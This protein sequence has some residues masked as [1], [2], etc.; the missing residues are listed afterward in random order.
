MVGVPR[1][2]GSACVYSGLHA[3]SSI[4]RNP[5]VLGGGTV[6]RMEKADW[7]APT[8]PV[9]ENN[10]LTECYRNADVIVEY[11]SGSSTAQ[12]SALP[13]KLIFSVES[14]QDWAL[15][16]QQEI[17]ARKLPS[18]AVVYHVDVGPT[19]KWG[20]PLDAANWRQFSRYATAIWSEPHFRHPDVVLIDGRLRLGCLAAVALGIRRKTVVLFDD[21]TSRPVY[22]RNNAIAEPD[23]IAG[24]MARFTLEPGMID[25]Q[26]FS[27]VISMF[28]MMSTVAETD[29]KFY[30]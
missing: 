2:E 3:K 23:L 16:L 6:I 24:R 26:N 22:A 27:A 25:H 15:R 5:A 28:S 12:A 19:G 9:E 20:R 10:L 8:M 13:S 11:G 14:D 21:Y 17:Y 30:N 18:P 7:L 1:D 4:R 29:H